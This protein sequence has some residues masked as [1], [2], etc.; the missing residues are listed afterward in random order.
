[1]E[2][3]IDSLRA[4]RSAHVAKLTDWLRIPSVSTDSS[5]KADV[6]RAGEWALAELRAAGF[7]GRIDDTPRHP[8]VFAKWHGAPGAPTVLVYGHFDVQP[9]EPLDLWR[10]GAF[11]PTL[12]GE[13]LVARGAT[14]DKGQ[15]LALVLGIG[16]A[17]RAAGKLPVNV[18]FLLEGEEEIG[19]P[20][21]EPYIRAH[22]DELAADVALISDCSQFAAGIPAI[23]V[24]LKGLVYMQVELVGPNRDLHSGSFGGAVENPAIALARML[25]SLHDDR[26]RVTIPGFYDQVRDISRAERDAMKKLPF[27]EKGFAADLGLSVERL[28]GESGWST[29]ERKWARPTLDVNGLLSGWTGE[30]AKTVLPSKAMAKFSMRLVPD[31][32]PKAIEKLVREHFARICPPTCTM[33]LGCDHGAEPVLVDA[34]SPWLAAASRAVAKGFGK[35]PVFIREGG[36]IPVVSVF[37]KQLG[38][39][40]ILLGLGL[41]DD[42]AHSPNEKFHLPD[43]HRGIETAAWLLEEMVR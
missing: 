8:I 29:L 39:E 11:E 32:D 24:G 40:T 6:R 23:T 1:M 12:E 18:T 14:D 20:N 19:S 26:G 28:K 37:K 35:P 33:K 13:D 22:R 30:G 36:S 38:I 34:E 10:H 5:R 7:E 21:L 25:A 42:N 4:A 15:A 17:L 16:G 31:Q 3:V 43:F 41:P 2:R 9:A 27:D